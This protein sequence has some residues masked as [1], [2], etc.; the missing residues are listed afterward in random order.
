MRRLA[1]LALL[2]AFSR[3]FA[4]PSGAGDDAAMPTG[5]PGAF[6]GSVSLALADDPEYGS[7]LLDALDAH[8]RAVGVMTSRREVD[9]YLEQSAA[10]SEDVK[11]LR[12]ALGREPLDAAKASALLL[13][14]ALARPRQCREVLDGLDALKSGIGRQAASMMR[15]A[16]GAGDKKLFA[17]LRAAGALRR[18]ERPRPYIRA[19]RLSLL[20]DEESAVGRDGVVLQDPAAPAAGDAAAPAVRARGAD[21]A[22]PAR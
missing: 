15:A 21:P 12:A 5:F 8:L 14:D 16:R 2:L 18:E 7:R 1:A 11:V 22:S 10:G 3:A 20:F 13:A 19:E 6:L 4:G 9:D 17:S